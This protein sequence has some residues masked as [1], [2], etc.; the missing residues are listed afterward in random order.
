MQTL[1]DRQGLK[2]ACPEEIAWS[3]HWIDDGQL[4][5]LADAMSKNSYGRYLRNLLRD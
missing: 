5:A 1:E 4:E 3:N 2:V